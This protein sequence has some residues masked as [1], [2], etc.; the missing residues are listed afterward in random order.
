MTKFGNQT[1]VYDAMGNP[2]TYLGKTA[3]WKGRQ[4][5]SFNGNT[6]AYDGRGRRMSKNSLIFLYDPRGRI[7]IKEM[8]LPLLTQTATRWYNIGTMHGATIRL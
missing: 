1:C 4:L 6:F 8:L 3:T 5:T 7:I 2:T